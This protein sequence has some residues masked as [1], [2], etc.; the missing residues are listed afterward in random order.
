MRV[1]RAQD[2]DLDWL[3]GQLRAFSTFF[4]GAR[5]LL[6]DEGYARFQLLAMI[7]GHLV[8]VAER[9]DGEL[10][11]FIAGFVGPHPYNPSLRVLSE[12]F[13]WVAEPHRGG[14]VGAILL[15]AFVA[16]GRANVDWVTMALERGSPVK[17]DSLLRRG[18]RLQERNYLLEVV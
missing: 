10:L 15:E 4:G 6:E 17:E 18:F 2:A 1:R 3:V 14:H 11:G 8:L 16:W 5:P 9:E 13:W 12:A 7:E